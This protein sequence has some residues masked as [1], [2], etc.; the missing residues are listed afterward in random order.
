MRRVY[1]MVYLCLGC[2]PR[3]VWAVAL[4]ARVFTHDPREQ[5]TH[6]KQKAQTHNDH[7]SYC[8]SYLCNTETNEIKYL[9]QH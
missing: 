9:F 1:L 3:R 5:I 8:A 4:V 6:T 2:R 7:K